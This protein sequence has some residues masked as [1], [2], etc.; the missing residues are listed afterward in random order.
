MARDFKAGHVHDFQR[1][2]FQFFGDGPARD[3][4]DAETD[5]DGGLDGLG[6]V[7]VHHMFE[8]LELETRVLESELDDAARTG[9]LF[10]HQKIG[11][12]ELV[13]GHAIGGERPR[14]DQDQFVLHEGFGVNAAVAGWSFD[15]AEGELVVEEKMHD[16]V[17]I[18]AVEGELDAG[19]LVE[20]GPEQARKNILRDRG[21]HTEG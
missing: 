16:F 20:E 14:H 18:A 13:V 21:G 7:E 4:A 1:A 19:M 8:R 3:E 15:E 9:T 2:Q 17:G 10:P 6:G 12:E 11:G 5:F